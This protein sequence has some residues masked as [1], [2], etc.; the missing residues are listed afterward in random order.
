MKIVLDKTYVKYS[1]YTILTVTIL[2][3]LYGILSNLDHI[4]KTALMVLGGVISVLTPLIIALVITYLFH[5]LVSRIEAFILMNVKLMAPKAE[6]NDQYGHLRRTISVLI[7]YLILIAIIA[8]FIYSIFVLISGSLPRNFDLKS[9]MDS[10]T[11]YTKS[12]NEL[13]LRLTASM[14]KSGLSGEVKNQLL[15]LIQVGQNFTGNAIAGL[16]TSLQGFGNNLLNILLGFIIA[17][18][19]LMDFQYFKSLYR[20]STALLFKRQHNEKLSD[21]LA[22]INGVVSS[23]IRGQLLVAL[24]VGVFSSIALYFVGLDFAVLVGMTAGLFNV[25]PY[26]GPLM[27]SIMAVIVGLLSGSPLKA[28]LAV[29]ALV[30]VQQI[31]SN[32][33]S[34]KIVGNSVGLHPVFIILS[35]IIGGSCFGLLGMLIA[36][37]VAGII[38]LLLNRWISFREPRQEK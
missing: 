22:D 9:M 38:K 19:L 10:I 2:F 37:P 12:Y 16:F 32:I 27:G 36:V 30:V 17:F 11:N 24:I 25:I 6:K 28:L 20:Q 34:P 13:F 3:I 35:I 1:I 31:D 21:F 14:E 29:A 4:L 23:F 7:T 33:I 15:R 8:I 18:Y 5:P 26:F